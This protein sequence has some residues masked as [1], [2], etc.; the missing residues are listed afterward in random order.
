MNIVSQAEGIFYLLK[1]LSLQAVGNAAIP[2]LLKALDIFE[3]LLNYDPNNSF[4]LRH[5]GEVSCI[6]FFLFFCKVL[7]LLSLITSKS[8]AS[9]DPRMAKG[10]SLMARATEVNPL[11][12]IAFL[13]RAKYLNKIGRWHQ[14]ED[15]YLKSLEINPNYPSSLEHYARLLGQKNLKESADL[16]RHR[17]N[18]VL[19]QSNLPNSVLFPTE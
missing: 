19:S 12:H 5:C 6:S 11:D 3:D 16:F 1:G 8:N 10:L 9:E 18:Q 4:A 13:L 7:A 17:L 15:L 2:L 14:S